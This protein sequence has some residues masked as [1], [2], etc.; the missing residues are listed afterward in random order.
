MANS[1]STL[2]RALGVSTTCVGRL[3]KV[4][5]LQRRPDGTFDLRVARKMLKM[6]Q[7]RRK[8]ELS[9]STE[10]K[11]WRE[12]T[13]RRL[14]ELKVG[15]EEGRL[16]ERAVIIRRAFEAEMSLKDKLLNLGD[17]IAGRLVGKTENEIKVIIGGRVSELLNEFSEN[18]KMV[19][20]YNENSVEK[21]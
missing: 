1:Y 18:Y 3:I 14:L 12:K 7:G 13:A 10:Q 19:T 4:D 9:L 17:E 2:A 6:R 11:L 5:G 16:L 21:S 8:G 15:Q 20:Q